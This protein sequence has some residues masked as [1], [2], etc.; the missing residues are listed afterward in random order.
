MLLTG[1]IVGT[2]Y[3]EMVSVRVEDGPVCEGIALMLRDEARHVAFHRDRMAAQWRHYFP[4]ERALWALQFQ[5]LVH[6]AQRAAWADHGPCL[7]ALGFEW[8]NFADR[9]RA[10]ATGFIDG[11]KVGGGCRGCEPAEAAARQEVGSV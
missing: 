7:R 11:L 10:L 9:T 4:V 3:Y 8:R 6:A 1:E 2:A 5:L